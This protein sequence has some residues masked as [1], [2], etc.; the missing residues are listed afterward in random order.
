MRLQRKDVAGS[1]SLRTDLADGS[2]LQLDLVVRMHCSDTLSSFVQAMPFTIQFPHHF[3]TREAKS[4]HYLKFL[5][6]RYVNL[7]C[8]DYVFLGHPKS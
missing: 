8:I 3:L 7:C 6:C 5:T 2:H 1:H 4:P